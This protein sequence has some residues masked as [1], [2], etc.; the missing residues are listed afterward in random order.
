MDQLSNIAAEHGLLAC[1]MADNRVYDRVSD[2]I[3][4]FHFSFPA[5]QRIFGAIEKQINTGSGATVTSL[6]ALFEKD[7]DLEKVGGG[8]YLVKIFTS[9]GGFGFNAENYAQTIRDLYTRRAL[10]IAAAEI[11]ALAEN[12]E[13]DD[14]LSEAEKVI[15]SIAGGQGLEEYTLAEAADGALRWIGEVAGGKIKPVMTGLHYLD[16]KIKGLFPGRLYVI[17]ARPGMGKTAFGLT[18]ADNIS[19]AV[20]CFFISL[21]MPKDELAMRRMAA[22]TGIS[23]DR[24]QEATGLTAEDFRS[25][26]AAR[27]DMA[28]SKLVI[29]DKGARSM[30]AIRSAARRFKRKYGNFVLFIDYLGLMD[31][32]REIKSRV[33][34]IEEITKSLK[35]LSKEI[36]IPVVIL[37]QLSRELEKRDNKRPGLSDLRDSGAIEQ[38]ADVVMFIHRPEVYLKGNPPIREARE[39]EDRFDGRMNDWRQEIVDSKGKAEIIIKKNRQGTDGTVIMNF[40]GER[41]MFS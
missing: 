16:H 12:H 30:T 29:A 3:R 39:T 20:P 21:E 27:A 24:Q 10:V 37:S 28:K 25:L 36:D 32:D 33:H 13:N 6:K 38:D 26:T 17:G 22:R 11:R 7:G 1:L 14:I 31:M 23:V 5:H 15:S 4:D 8:E 18:V 9:L 41:Q 34:Q 40:D 35:A 2:I 19:A